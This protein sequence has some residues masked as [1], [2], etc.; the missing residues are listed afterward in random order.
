MKNIEKEILEKFEKVFNDNKE[1][2][3]I[4][5]ENFFETNDDCILKFLSATLKIKYFGSKI[6][7]HYTWVR[8]DCYYDY[9]GKL[10]KDGEIDINISLYSFLEDEYTGASE[11]TFISGCGLRYENYDDELGYYSR[12]ISNYIINEVVHGLIDGLG[13][14]ITE[15]IEEYI[16]WHAFDIVHDEIY[17]NTKAQ[18]CFMPTMYLNEDYMKNISLSEFLDLSTDYIGDFKK[19]AEKASKEKGLK[20][21]EYTY[22]MFQE[23]YERK[24]KE[25]WEI[26]R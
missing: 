24:L 8:G 26:V 23:I 1:E 5:V 17:D 9:S 12:D 14:E 13:Y 15:D 6:P 11:A 2:I 19:E 21:I 4:K 10:K 16:Y 20:Y 22:E 7:E 25:K 3:F 18:S